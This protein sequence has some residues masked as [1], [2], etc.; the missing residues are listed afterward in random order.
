MC[1]ERPDVLDR[2]N[3]AA[4]AIESLNA[5]V[6]ADKSLDDVLHG[7]AAYAVNA[8]VGADA[9]SITVIDPPLR[10]VA[11]TDEDVLALDREQY[12]SRRGPCLGRA[13]AKAGA[14]CHTVRRGPVAAVRHGR[15]RSRC[16][17][18]PV[19]SVDHRSRRAGR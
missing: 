7:V 8:V 9:V 19:D 13:D 14:G 5:V 16:A 18:H 10:T 2:L 6:M 12:A 3:A 11:C 1:S 15:P 4:A 17:R